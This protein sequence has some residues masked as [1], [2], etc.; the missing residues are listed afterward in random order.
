MTRALPDVRHR[1][2]TR[3]DQSRWSGA[4]PVPPVDGFAI[5]GHPIEDVSDDR[6]DRLDEEVPPLD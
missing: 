3:R 1:H 2:G 4:T 6:Q 5:G